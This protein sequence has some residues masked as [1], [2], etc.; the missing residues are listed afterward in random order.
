MTPPTVV[1]EVEDKDG[2][3][4]TDDN[5][6]CPTVAGVAK[7]FGCP[8]PDTDKDG[9]K[10][11]EDKCPNQPGMAR[12]EGCPIPDTDGDGLN[13]EKDKC[14]TIAGPLSNEGCPI[15]EEP[16]AVFVTEEM[17]QEVNTAAKNIF[18]ETGKATLLK[19]SFVALQEV[20]DLLNENPTVKLEI[21]GYTDNTGAA[22]TNLVLSQNR[23]KA[24]LNYFVKNGISKE[25]LSAKGF[26]VQNPIASNKT[27]AGR[28]QNRRVVMNVIP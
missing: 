6:K 26:G 16:K 2:D 4:I 21:A 13:D 12:F 19:K 22:K 25:R 9:I 3:G 5:D 10:D 23:A 28:A 15:K 17:K 8:V 24:V 11:D 18:F 7:Y 1:A 27:A 14:P 20:V